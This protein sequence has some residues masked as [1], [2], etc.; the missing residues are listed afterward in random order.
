[1]DEKQIENLI[2]LAAQKL[3][4]NPE[5]LKSTAMSGNVDALLSK[6]DKKSADKVRS[7][8]KDKNLTDSLAEKF[9]K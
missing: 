2:K 5:E 1:M 3:N 4:M 9:K 6:M 8:M 7:A